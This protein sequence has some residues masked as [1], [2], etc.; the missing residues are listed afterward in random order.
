MARIGRGRVVEYAFAEL[1]RYFK[2]IDPKS[3]IDARVYEKRDESKPHILWVGLDGSVPESEDDSIK[4]EVNNGGG[5][6]TGSNER[7][8][9]LAVYRFL[10]ELGCRWVRPGA[11]GE[12][13]P[14]IRLE[15]SILNVSVNETPS[16]R[17]RGIC[18][19][20]QVNYEHV[21]DIIEWI[22]KLGMNSYFM[23][24]QI[25]SY[26]FKRWYN[27]QKSD[28]DIP[29]DPVDDDVAHIW[30]RIEEEIVKRGLSYHAVGHSWTCEA[31][32]VPGTEW[33]RHE[34]PL[35]E[36]YEQ[37]L[38]LRD[39]KRELWKYSVIN[40]NLCYSNKKVRDRLVD[41]VVEYCKNHKAV[42]Y[43]HFWL[44]DG[45][46]NHCECEECVKYRPSD[47]YIV[48]LNE[49]DEALAEAGLDTKLV[50]LIYEDLL[51]QPEHFKLK[52]PERFTL[53]FAPITRSYR[54]AY[55]DFTPVDPSTLTPY[56]RNK[57]TKP[58]SVG[59]NVA[60]L[61]LWQQM[62][63]GDSFDFAYHLMWHHYTDPGYYATAKIMHLDM[64][65]LHKI[66]LNGM[67]SCQLNRAFM[68]TALPNYAMAKALWDKESEFEDVCRE[69][70]TA[71]FGK[72]GDKVDEYL[73][74]LSD[75]FDL[76]IARDD[77]N[78][79]LFISNCTEA[80][81]VISDFRDKYIVPNADENPS[82][83]YLLYHSE[84]CLSYADL[85]LAGARHDETEYEKQTERFKAILLRQRPD[86]HHVFDPRVANQIYENFLKKI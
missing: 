69:Y 8:V 55:A 7:S 67:M 66:G 85:A 62:F 17:H 29:V 63:A 58:K 19:E 59:E 31:F 49:L 54:R 56:I 12:V 45:E 26:F 41:A 21:C 83:K 77:K 70:Y 42:D 86:T 11:D 38:A 50:F 64:K 40:S 60:F 80:K 9:L 37:A 28:E 68:P 51:W 74:R 65:N 57:L 25:P 14:N 3:F 27:D 24:F 20:G 23:Q 48:L 33:R 39:G 75:L 30:N 1:E 35:P 10:F 18:I 15:R 4:I 61:K 72:D 47:Y 71:A 81:S 36:D 73:H 34:E 78:L 46:N 6:I 5:I 44:A 52:N 76:H 32:G 82:W 13:I 53:M 43:L 16:L 84:L 2:R 79:P 22:P